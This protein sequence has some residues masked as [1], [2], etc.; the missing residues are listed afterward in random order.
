M[1]SEG[2]SF[3]FSAHHICI[4]HTTYTYTDQYIQHIQASISY[5]YTHMN[6]ILHISTRKYIHIHIIHTCEHTTHTQRNRNEVGGY[7]G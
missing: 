5:T 7:Y 6:K 1:R 3:L 2:L 4:L